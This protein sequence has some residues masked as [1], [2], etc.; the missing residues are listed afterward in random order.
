MGGNGSL[1]RIV[2][3]VGWKTPSLS[4]TGTSLAWCGDYGT[5]ELSSIDAPRAPIQI[6]RRSVSKRRTLPWKMMIPP[7]AVLS[8]QKGEGIEC[9][10]FVCCLKKNLESHGR[11]SSEGVSDLQMRI[12]TLLE[13]TGK[14][15]WKR[16]EVTYG[17]T[18]AVLVL[19]SSEE[20]KQIVLRYTVFP[21]L[22]WPLFVS[23]G[24]EKER[25]DERGMGQ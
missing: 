1:R 20:R 10:F 9:P 15:P 22:K 25:R 24:S 12:L 3:N 11:G 4:F 21:A 8:F 17:A 18:V 5:I 23:N 16:R 7:R 13:L 19:I 6:F 2:W 14:G